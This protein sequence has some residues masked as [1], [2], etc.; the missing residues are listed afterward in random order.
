MDKLLVVE[1]AYIRRFFIQVVIYD[2][3]DSQKCKI[4]KETDDSNYWFYSSAYWYRYD[5]IV[6]ACDSGNSNRSGNPCYRATEFVWARSL[7]K[8]VKN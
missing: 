1:A 8:E 4:G 3:A 5:C 2:C 6:R 7:L